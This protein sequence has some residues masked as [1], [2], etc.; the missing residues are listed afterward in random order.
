MKFKAFKMDGLGNDFL[1]IDNRNQKIIL[2]SEQILKLSNR[3]TGIGFDQLIYIENSTEAD[4]EIKYFNSDGQKA[5]A[6]GNGN[7]CVSDI[8]IREKNKENITFKVNN[9]VHHGSKNND[10]LI[11][12]IMP[13]PNVNLSEIP[14][15]NEV[16]KNPLIIEI[17]NKRFEGHLIN[18]GNPHIVFF[19]K[20]SDKELLKIGPHIENLRYF[21]DRINV[22]FADVK[23]K[24][25]IEINVWE[26]G[27]GKTLA[28][29]TAACATAYIASDLKITNN[30]VNIHFKKG[31]LLIKVNSDKTIKMSG[32]VSEKKE[33]EVIL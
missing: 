22:T 26:R 3:K 30:P 25:D 29:G 16:K 6:C 2:N 14:V 11:D 19:E 10:N 8:L 7:R 33:I 24:N 5:D 1:I 31:Y 20:I 21:P 28:C 12:V 27:A 9:F 18:V 32:P 13:K 23:N 4:A 15:T 17:N